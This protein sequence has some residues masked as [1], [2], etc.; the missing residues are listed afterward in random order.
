MLRR[1]SGCCRSTKAYECGAVWCSERARSALA[2]RSRSADEADQ[3]GAGR[4][5][6]WDVSMCA[7]VEPFASRAWWL[8]VV[9]AAQVIRVLA[10][11]ADVLELARLAERR[12]T[13]YDRG[14]WSTNVLLRGECALGLAAADADHMIVCC[15]VLD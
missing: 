4:R 6:R 3:I 12:A 10:T 15:G 7:V 9:P 8:R 11:A 2:A 5:A 14:W 1:S 13:F